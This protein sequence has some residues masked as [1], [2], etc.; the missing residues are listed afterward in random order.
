MTRSTLPAFKSALE[1]ALIFFAYPTISS[2]LIP[3]G[4]KGRFYKIFV[5]TQGFYRLGDFPDYIHEFDGFSRRNPGKLQP[6]RLQ[7]H[8]LHE[9]L[10]QCKFSAGIVITFQ[11]MAFTG[12][13][14]GNPYSI[15]SFPESR[16]EKLG[17]HAP[18]TRNADDPDI[19]RIIHP[20]HPCQ[21]SCA[22][23]TPGA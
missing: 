16:Q 3:A 13:S 20:A 10:K 11:V 5:G 4:R 2:H 14:P 6:A 23:A 7:S 8:V 22:V 17:T 9:V 18:G 1:I 12:M 15:C 21:I 19:G